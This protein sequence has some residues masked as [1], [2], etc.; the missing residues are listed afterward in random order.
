A[1]GIRALAAAG[2]GGFG[3][4]VGAGRGVRGRGVAALVAVAAGVG[5]AALAAGL[6][7]VDAIVEYVDIGAAAL[8]EDR[9]RAQGWGLGEGGQLGGGP[10][11]DD[12]E[13][14]AP[15][16]GDLGARDVAAALAGDA[17]DEP[18]IAG[19]VIG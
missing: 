3:A 5:S 11:G 6:D 12:A 9:P 4:G 14:E 15:G 17:V 13:V 2:G 18:E 19:A 7:G 16:G 10:H 1:G 8:D